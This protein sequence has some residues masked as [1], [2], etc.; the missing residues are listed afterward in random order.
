MDGRSRFT[1]ENKNVLRFTN[2]R[3]L[4]TWSATSWMDTSYSR[5]RKKEEMMKKKKKIILFSTQ[6]PAYSNFLIF[7]PM[8]TSTS[9]SVLYLWRTCHFCSLFLCLR[10]CNRKIVCRRAIYTPKFRNQHLDKI[11][12]LPNFSLYILSTNIF[13]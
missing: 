4:W 6:V 10:L 9:A 11:L 5:R 13:L 7:Y 8:S 2:V 12:A 1:R 3:K